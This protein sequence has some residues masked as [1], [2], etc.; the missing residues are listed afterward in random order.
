MLFW[1]IFQYNCKR[2][3]LVTKKRRQVELE[4]RC[5][6]WLNIKSKI[7]ELFLYLV[8]NFCW[9]Y[10]DFCRMPKEKHIARRA[11]VFCYNLFIPLFPKRPQNVV[12]NVN[13]FLL[14]CFISQITFTIH[15]VKNIWRWLIKNEY[16]DI[17]H[18]C[19]WIKK[20]MLKGSFAK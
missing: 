17:L 13:S 1:F 10:G 5:Y 19:D 3:N 8:K 2:E 20:Q 15:I 9:K 18:L 11:V 14:H 16:L 4:K 12:Y 7:W 6:S